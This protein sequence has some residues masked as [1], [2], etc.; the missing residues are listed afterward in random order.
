M[1]GGFGVLC[2]VRR[3]S[4]GAASTASAFFEPACVLF[5]TWLASVSAP[6]MPRNLLGAVSEGTP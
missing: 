5:R 6:A 1:L 4:E 3:V 2:G